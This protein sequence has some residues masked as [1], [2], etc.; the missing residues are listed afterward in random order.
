MVA[1]KTTSKEQLIALLD[2]LPSEVLAEIADFI[3]FQRYKQSKTTREAG[4][5]VPV[6]LGGLWAGAHISD[7]DIAAVRREMWDGI[8]DRFK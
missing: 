4:R 6:K 3:E 7:E 1:E 5:P 8:E 2:D